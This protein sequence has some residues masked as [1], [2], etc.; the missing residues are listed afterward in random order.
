MAARN[1]R[2][3]LAD[4][5]PAS[6]LV[7]A[8]PAMLRAAVAS[9]AG[10]ALAAKRD[11]IRKGIGADGKPLPPVKPE[12]RPDG[13]DGKPLDP[14]YAESRTYKLLDARQDAKGVTLYWR[15][16]GRKSWTTILGYHADG[17]VRG[18]PVRDVIG[19]SPAARRKLRSDMSTW[20]RNVARRNARRAAN[21]KGTGQAKVEE[22]AAKVETSV[23]AK[24]QAR[25]QTSSAD[26]SID[27]EKVARESGGRVV[28]KSGRPD[29]RSRK[30]QVYETGGRGPRKAEPPKEPKVPKTPRGPAKVVIPKVAVAKV[31]VPKVK[32]AVAKV[33]QPPPPPP[34]PRTFFSPPVP[35]PRPAPAATAAPDF[36]EFVRS[37]DPSLRP[38]EAREL[39]LAHVR[40][41]QSPVP[42]EIK[43][44]GMTV[45]EA[46][47]FIEMDGYRIHF[48]AAADNQ[49]PIVQ[50]IRGLAKEPPLPPVL[51]ST[52]RNVY[53][54]SQR[55]S[56]DPRWEREYK[57]PGF[58]SLA[59][60]GDG[61]VVVYNGE[62]LSTYTLVHEAGHN[63][64]TATY[65][66]VTPNPSS[67]FARAAGAEP[68]P[69]AY[70]AVAIWEDF[71]DSCRLAVLEPAAFDASSPLRAAVI[72]KLFKDPGYGG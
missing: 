17:L 2:V 20:W 12:S 26:R 59:T 6:D 43:R 25:V 19:L 53:L 47:H 14:H 7:D 40:Q 58:K 10:F 69:T 66:T 28:Y 16:S 44:H 57:R 68:P 71:A 24:A 21:L 72:R 62:S 13:A 29:L 51:A 60:G 55:N 11:D 54:T 23:K 56:E 22:K 49:A 42:V 39:V 61:D 50:T 5:V 35:P 48:T 18:A 64:A 1:I 27:L 45:P 4:Y 30:I 70:A 67:D 65:G 8:S 3:Q 15:A 31:S 41:H 32:V 52:T 46:M 33:V 38:S 36:R 37:L 34:P 63:L 9:L